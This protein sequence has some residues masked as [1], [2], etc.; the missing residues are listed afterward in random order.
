MRSAFVEVAPAL[1]GVIHPS[2]HA[3]IAEIRALK[4]ITLMGTQPTTSQQTSLFSADAVTC[5]QTEGSNSSALLP[6]PIS[7]VPWPPVGVDWYY[8]DSSCAIAC[9]DCREILPHLPKV[10]AVITDPPY[11]MAFRSNYRTVK[12]GAIVGDD[13]LPLD[14]LRLAMGRAVRFTYAFCRW[15]NLH[16]MPK[17]NSVLAWVKNNWSMGDLKHEHGRQWEACCFYAHDGHEFIKRIPDVIFEERTGNELHPTQKP[18]NLIRVLIQA[19]RCETILDPFMGSGT[20]LVAAKNLGRKAIGIE[21]EERYCEIAAKRLAQEVF[22][23]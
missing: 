11:G 23:F 20:T 10:D 7:L 6:S 19:N 14:A 21:I 17:P 3:P 4:G 12:H 15:D 1:S 9:A 18:E 16:E 2:A 13:A 8:S 5:K 22:Q